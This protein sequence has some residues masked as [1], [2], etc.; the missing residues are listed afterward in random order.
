M[1]FKLKLMAMASVGFMSLS[2]ALSGIY[3]LVW[4]TSIP[5][6]TNVPRIEEYGPCER[7]E[8]DIFYP[9]LKT[10]NKPDHI[11]KLEDH[12]EMTISNLYSMA[13]FEEYEYYE[14]E[15]IERELTIDPEYVKSKYPKAIKYIA[16]CLWG[17][18]RGAVPMH[19][20]AVVWCILNRVDSWG[21]SG[22]KAI[23]DTITAKNQFT[24]WHKWNPIWENLEEVAIDVLGRWELEKL[25]ETNVGRVLPKGYC[26]FLGYGGV[27]HFRNAY[28]NGKE[29]DWSLP[30]PYA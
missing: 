10:I 24:G 4:G 16:Q 18:C 17:E 7:S 3:Y 30:N 23:I 8:K 11:E 19:K 12:F 20:A 15:I 9:D 26:W 13:Q 22:E 27:N 25:G 28:R 21:G 5:V 29:W 6:E 1:I 2:I 14:E